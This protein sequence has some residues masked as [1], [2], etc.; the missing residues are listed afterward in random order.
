MR[1]ATVSRT[2]HPIVGLPSANVASLIATMWA[3]PILI[4]A[5]LF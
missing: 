3:R 1:I 4:E 5:S 2:S